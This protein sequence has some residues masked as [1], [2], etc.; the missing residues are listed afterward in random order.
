MSSGC[1]TTHSARFQSSGRGFRSSVMPD[2][3]TPAGGGVAQS[4]HR[5]APVRRERS[6]VDRRY[7]ARAGDSTT[8]DRG[9]PTAPV[10]SGSTPAAKEPSMTQDLVNGARDLYRDRTAEIL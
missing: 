7:T 1:A 9:S 2:G 6:R 5:R 8:R 10:P 3:G 4:E